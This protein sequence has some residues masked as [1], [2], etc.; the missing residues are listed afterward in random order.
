MI[1]AVLASVDFDDDRI[2]G[3]FADGTEA[4]PGADALAVRAALVERNVARFAGLRKLYAAAGIEAMC[5]P[6]AP[7]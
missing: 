6:D 2:S 7:A 1:H 5:M 3:I 4:A